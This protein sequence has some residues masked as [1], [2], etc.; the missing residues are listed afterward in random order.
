MPHRPLRR[1]ALLSL[2]ATP[3]LLGAGLAAPPAATDA[4]ALVRDRVERQLA[5]LEQSIL[6]HEHAAPRAALQRRRFTVETFLLA[7]LVPQAVAFAAQPDLAPLWRFDFRGEPRRLAGPAGWAGRAALLGGPRGD[8]IEGSFLVEQLEPAGGDE[9]VAIGGRFVADAASVVLAATW[10]EPCLGTSAVD[11]PIVPEAF[12]LAWDADTREVAV[13][14]PSPASHREQR[15][16]EPPRLEQFEDLYD[17]FDGLRPLPWVQG[18]MSSAS[19]HDPSGRDDRE[20]EAGS[21]HAADALDGAARQHVQVDE[22]GGELVVTIRQPPTACRWRS[23]L[24]YE[25]LGDVTGEPGLRRPLVPEGEIA[26][27][28]GP[29][30]A[31][32]RIRRGSIAGSI[33]RDGRTLARMRWDS[34]EP[35][36]TT[37]AREAAARLRAPFEPA[38]ARPVSLGDADRGSIGPPPFADREGDVGLLGR[39]DAIDPLGAEMRRIRRELA[40]AVRD[41]SPEAVRRIFERHRRAIA[42]QALDPSTAWRSCEAIAEA[43]A[44]A[45]DLARLGPWL[46][47]PC[48]LA[49]SALPADPLAELLRDRIAMGRFGAA[50]WL[51]QELSTRDDASDEQRGAAARVHAE[52][53]AVASDPERPTPAWWEPP[54]RAMLAEAIAERLAVRSRTSSPPIG[55]PPGPQGTRDLAGALR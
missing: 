25:L 44:E 26:S 43:L 23:G 17:L 10:C 30:D 16:D 28:E 47:G 11:F 4:R 3:M 12:L 51:A 2:A 54:G 32:F 39:L 15:S 14:L 27:L 6:D 22:A 38:L 13:L 50:A 46:E 36:D 40:E 18:S 33:E 42:E 52:L 5:A 41:A 9:A 35:R 29:I 53:L 24:R 45:S 49:A 20:A 21:R 48:S 7:G 55:A 34:I 1:F 8:A 31:V 19:H 37:E